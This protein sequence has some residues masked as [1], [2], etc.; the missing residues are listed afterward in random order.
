MILVWVLSVPGCGGGG[1]GGSSS[2]DSTLTGQA[3]FPNS[4]GGGP[5]ANAPFQVV[6]FEKPP[7]N[8][9]VFTGTTNSVGGYSANIARTSS[10]AVIVTGT[11]GGS[12]KRKGETVRVSGLVNP[13]RPHVLKNFD[14]TT[15]IA[16]EAGFSA[17][18]D[19]SITAQELDAQRI[20][21]LEQAAA[22]F[23]DS[24]NF[25]DPASVTAAAN[26]VREITHDGAKPPG[27]D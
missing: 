22:T 12:G 1:D 21:N 9:V 24:T 3:V 17:V 11:V 20:S 5:V 18:L 23:V 16:C 27:H 19:G 13:D 2:Q 14:G 7:D 26:A 15:D 25:F 6:D 10:A 4:V 8:N